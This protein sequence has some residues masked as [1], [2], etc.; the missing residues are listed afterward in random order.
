MTTG[1]NV[2]VAEEGQNAKVAN[3]PMMPSQ[4]EVELHET[5]HIPFRSWC[6][7]CVAGK[8]KANP[9][10]SQGE[11]QPCGV[12]IVSIDYAFLGDKAPPKEQEE[13]SSDEDAD[14]EAEEATNTKK[15]LTVLVMRDRVTRYVTASV[16]P[17]KGDHPYTVQRVGTDIT[18][19][20]GYKRV[21]IKSD[22]E[23]AIKKLKATVRR[24]YSIEI[25]DELS[26]VGDSQSNGDVEITV[27]LVEGQVRTIKCQVEHR[28][29]QV[30]PT[31]HP[32]LPWLVR[33][34]G[35][36]ISRYQRGKDGLTAYRRLRGRDFDRQIAEFGECIWYFKTQMQTQRQNRTTLGNRNLS[37]C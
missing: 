13:G 33:H 19:V 21:I 6:P 8:A 28:L 26:P 4:E 35:A 7:F 36:T 30:L 10:M 29:G 11:C 1:V 9:H 5:T 12:N 31:E 22:Q 34:A 27:Q 25:P 3:K 15:N 16:V 24:E 23:R 20:L 37:W 2:E 14:D 17:R 32:L 18:E